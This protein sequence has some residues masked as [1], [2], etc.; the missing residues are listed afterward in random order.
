M[1][2]VH[3]AASAQVTNCLLNA[4]GYFTMHVHGVTSRAYVVETTT[5]LNSPIQWESVMTNYVSF[6]YTNF[7]T[8]NDMARFYRIVTDE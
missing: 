4:E 3:D 6:N 7:L 5:N 2:V 1:L 8:S